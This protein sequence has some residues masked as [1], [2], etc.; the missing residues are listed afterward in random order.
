MKLVY[1]G[2]EEAR[3]AYWKLAAQINSADNQQVRIKEGHHAFQVELAT[4]LSF[5]IG[6]L[7]FFD[8]RVAEAQDLSIEEGNREGTYVLVVHLHIPDEENGFLCVQVP[9]EY[10]ETVT[11]ASASNRNLLGNL[12]LLQ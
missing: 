4:G 2:A 3:K 9:E 7:Q 12:G 11:T 10:I 1:N 6:E 8:G 5:P